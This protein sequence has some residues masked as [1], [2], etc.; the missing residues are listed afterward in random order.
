MKITLDKIYKFTAQITKLS[1]YETSL[2]CT[3]QFLYKSDE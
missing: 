1:D 2:V 3:F